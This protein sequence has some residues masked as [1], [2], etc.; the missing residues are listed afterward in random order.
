MNKEKKRQATNPSRD[1][2]GTKCRAGSGT[3][4]LFSSFHTETRAAAVRTKFTP[5]HK[6]NL[7]IFAQPR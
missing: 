4:K 2:S 5:S 1:Q 7:K 3:K 6:P